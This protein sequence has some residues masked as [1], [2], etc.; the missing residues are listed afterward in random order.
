[1]DQNKLDDN[2]RYWDRMAKLYAPVQEFSNRKVYKRAMERCLPYIR[3]KDVLELACGSGQFTCALYQKA[4]YWKATDFSKKMIQELKKKELPDLHL[5]VEDATKL[6][7]PDHSFDV[8]LIANALHIVPEPDRVMGEI[9]RVLKPGG[10]LLAPNFVYE[11]KVNR[12]RM[13]VTTMTGF[14]I[15][16]SWSR[17]DYLDY[18]R[19]EG[20]RVIDAELIPGDPLPL[21]FA[22]FGKR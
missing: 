3:N 12:F 7:Y 14:Q 8:I 5:S 17:R 18:I 22:A 13:W 21:L 6:P 2:K 11:G 20:Y 10:I 19:N 9:T 4:S 1:M 16:H 15:F